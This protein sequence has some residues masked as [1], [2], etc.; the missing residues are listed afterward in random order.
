[1]DTQSV[2]KASLFMTITSYLGIAVFLLATMVSCEMLNERFGMEDDNLVEEFEED[3]I[4][5][6]T[7]VRID[8]TPTSPER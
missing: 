3:F 1:M 4:Y 5:D 8:L 6:K 2:M 7:G